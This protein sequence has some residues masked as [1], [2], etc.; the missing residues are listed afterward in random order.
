LPWGNR[1]SMVAVAVGLRSVGGFT[2]REVFPI[3]DP[4]PTEITIRSGDVLEGDV[5][6][7]DR[8]P[9]LPEEI[10]KRDVIVFWSYQLL[11]GSRKEAASNRVSG[12]VMIPR[13]QN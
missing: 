6:L 9:T 12:Y 2:L 5:P 3:D 11:F 13:Q 4:V 10:K 1:Y 7:N 8:F